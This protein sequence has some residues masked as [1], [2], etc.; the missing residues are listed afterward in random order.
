MPQ[1]IALLRGVNVGGRAIVPM[2]ALRDLFGELGFVNVQTLLQSGNVVF[3]ADRTTPAAAQAAI[4]AALFTRFKKEIRVILRSRKDLA[5]VV[6]RNPFPKAARDDP[7]H[8]V[9]FFLAAKPSASATKSLA[10][11]NPAEPFRLDGS[12]LFIHYGAGIGTSKF[13]GAVIEK[14]LATPGTARNWNTI[15]KL[16]AL[17]EELKDV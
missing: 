10:R 2:A 15:T 11:L 14:T 5:N 16:I 4:E 17:A 13:T 6:A 3:D 9:V 8:L 7:S 12:S 1:F